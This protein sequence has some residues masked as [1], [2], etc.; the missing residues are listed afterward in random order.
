MGKKKK[1]IN[2]VKN[3][4]DFDDPNSQINKNNY[5]LNKIGN[6]KKKKHVMNYDFFR[7]NNNTV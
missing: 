5:K 6:M 2:P 4:K 1:I 7:D 3:L